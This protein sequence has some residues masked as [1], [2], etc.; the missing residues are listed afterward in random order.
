MRSY[1]QY[2]AVAK[3]LDLI[4]NRGTLLIV[5]DLLLRGPCRYTDLRAGPPGIATNLL[6]DRL[7]ELEEAGVVARGEPAPPVATALFSLT[8]RGE[9]L[10]D[11]LYELGRW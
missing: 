11:L 10:K 9:Q 4:G 6:A 7:R 1:G 2:C 3:A 5:L 8:P